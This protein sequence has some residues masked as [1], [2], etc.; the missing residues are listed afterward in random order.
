MEKTIT[1]IEA[2][3]YAVNTLQTTN[4]PE[5]VTNKVAGLL[6]QYE[7]R[8]AAPRQKS[9][10]VIAE[11]D[12]IKENIRAELAGG[13]YATAKELADALSLSVQKVSAMLR[14]MP[15]IVA[16]REGKS[17]TFGLKG[18]EDGAEVEEVGA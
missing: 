15:D 8:K 17:P 6:A 10:R 12:A 4:A 3:T 18:E 1:M 13:Y 14:E 16:D 11:N 5:D 7:A 9:K 2:L